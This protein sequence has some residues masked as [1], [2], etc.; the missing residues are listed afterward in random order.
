MSK[1]TTRPKGWT[2]PQVKR[3]GEIKDVA[4]AQGA[5]A[6]GAGAKT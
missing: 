6:Q 5:G 1:G 4:G 3:L 2:K